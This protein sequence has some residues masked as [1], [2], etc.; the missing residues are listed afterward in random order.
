MRELGDTWRAYPLGLRL[1]EGKY[2]RQVNSSPKEFF[3]VPQETLVWV[4]TGV[5]L[6]LGVWRT[7][8]MC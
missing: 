3:S 7:V 6:E 1:S 8:A 2:P 4:S 5:R